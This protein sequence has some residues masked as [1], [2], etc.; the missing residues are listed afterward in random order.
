MCCLEV[1]GPRLLLVN[2]K[3]TYTSLYGAFSAYREVRVETEFVST[4]Q[5]ICVVFCPKSTEDLGETRMY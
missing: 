4:S 2:I 1:E 3:W 5:Y